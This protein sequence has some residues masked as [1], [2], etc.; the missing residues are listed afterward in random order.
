[1]VFSGSAAMSGI[2]APDMRRNRLMI[3]LADLRR[4]L[5]ACRER[6][7]E[8]FVRGREAERQRRLM[9]PLQASVRGREA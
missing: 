4:M 1:M 8:H 2:L 6:G 7:R 3:R 5:Y 9:R